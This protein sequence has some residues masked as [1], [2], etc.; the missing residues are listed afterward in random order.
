MSADHESKEEAE[1]KLIV[2][3]ASV[4]KDGVIEA[5]TSMRN[6][7]SN[8]VN[9]AVPEMLNYQIAVPDYDLPIEEPPAKKP[10]VSQL[11][12]DKATITK[13]CKPSSRRPSVGKSLV[14]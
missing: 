9:V 1:G 3:D 12:Q 10:Q 14:Q 2:T 6:S 7:K 11:P 5:E 13:P 8:D 4:F